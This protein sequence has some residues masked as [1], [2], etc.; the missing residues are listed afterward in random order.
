MSG[1]FAAYQPK[2]C[3]LF[4][5]TGFSSSYDKINKAQDKNCS[6]R[7]EEGLQSIDLQKSYHE[8]SDESDN[9]HQNKTP[10][11]NLCPLRKPT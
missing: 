7:K 5:I 2:S 1:L 6:E 11:L 9:N 4:L 3:V 10:T 8:F